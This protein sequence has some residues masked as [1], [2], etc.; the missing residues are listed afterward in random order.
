ME[1]GS[2]EVA[3]GHVWERRGAHTSVLR[4][5]QHQTPQ[6]ELTRCP[7]HKREEL[8]HPLS[9]AQGLGWGCRYP[10]PK[11][12]YAGRGRMSGLI[13]GA[14]LLHKGRNTC[15]LWMKPK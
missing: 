6:A 7:T 1:L 2:G 15:G 12:P 8:S 4:S 14:G 3:K 9:S 10:K 13:P 5:Q 11:A